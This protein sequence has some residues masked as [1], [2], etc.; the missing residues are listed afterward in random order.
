MLWA[1]IA[2]SGALMLSWILGIHILWAV[3]RKLTGFIYYMDD[4]NFPIPTSEELEEIVKNAEF[5]R[6]KGSKK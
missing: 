2:V 4:H 1:V 6:V 3:L 5:K